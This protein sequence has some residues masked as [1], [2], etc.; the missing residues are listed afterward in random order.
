MGTLTSLPSWSL[1]TK[2]LGVP[3]LLRPTL[4]K[5]G[6]TRWMVRTTLLG[7]LALSLTLTVPMLVKCPNS[8]VPFLTIG[9]EVSVFRPLRLRTVA[10]PETIVIR[11]FPAAQL[12][13][14]LGCVVTVLIGMVMLGEQV[15]SRLCRAVTGAD[16]IMLTPF[17]CGLR[18][19]VSV[20]L[21]ATCDACGVPS[22]ATCFFAPVIARIYGLL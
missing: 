11:P 22:L 16:G 5:A 8:I 12:Q 17:G 1:T 6:F 3:T 19:Q 15:R 10:L 18:R 2:Y 14:S 4:L 20:L 13:V 7:L 9:P 21:V